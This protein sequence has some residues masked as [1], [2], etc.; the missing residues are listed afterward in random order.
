MAKRKRRPR[1]M[2]KRPPAAAAARVAPG[3]SVP[4]ARTDFIWWAAVVTAAA[5][6]AVSA[7]VYDPGTYAPFYVRE[8]MPLLAS[9]LV[10]AALAFLQGRRSAQALRLD[11]LDALAAGFAVW[12]LASVVVSPAPLVAIF[13]AYNTGHG[14]LFWCAVMLTFIALRRLLSGERSQKA[15][16]W[17][18]AAALV[19]AAAIAVAQAFGA[20]SL[21]AVWG[22]VVRQ[23]RVPGTTGSPLGL[24]AFGL[25]SI[26]MLG[27]LDLWRRYGPTWLAAMVGSAAG[28]ICVAMSV[29]RAAA[30]GFGAGVLVLAVVWWLARR[31]SDLI[32]LGCVLL[33]A[34][35]AS[36]AYGAGPGD[37]LFS[38]LQGKPGGGLNSS[39]EKR[40]MLWG[41]AAKAFAARPLTGVGSG[42]F[43]V[44]DRLYRPAA[45][46]IALPWGVGS[47]AHSL[48]LL[49]AA[50]SGA[51]GLV[52]G[53]ALLVL[54][55]VRL[56]RGAR[57]GPGATTTEIDRAEPPPVRSTAARASSE[58]ALV[59]LLA[60]AAFAALSPLYACFAVAAAVFAGAAC[61]PPRTAGGRV[62]E[63]GGARGGRAAAVARVCGLI[64]ASIALAVVLVLG[65]QWWR[66]E[67][68]LVRSAQTGSV[69]DMQRAAD[70][71]PWEPVYLLQAG[72]AVVGE[73]QRRQDEAAVAGG[74]ALLQRGVS[75]DRTAP[76]GY[77]DLARLDM[78]AGASEAAVGELRKALAWNPQHPALQGLWA[79]AALQAQRDLG[80]ERLATRLI[81]GLTQLPVDTPDGWY[82]LAQAYDA[83]GQ[84]ALAKAARERAHELNPKLDAA[85]YR[86]RLN[87]SER[88]GARA[89]PVSVTEVYPPALSTTCR[90]AVGETPAS[91][92][93]WAG[94]SVRNR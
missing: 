69:T 10:L 84:T 21:W 62:W 70:L 30:L 53:G 65:V 94:S 51:P 93:A 85:A 86:A 39:D 9:A 5:L 73:A 48:P 68:A 46:R 43:I 16:V 54:V 47:D 36:L 22:A 44:A 31:R 2:P 79:Y 89:A 13:G 41:E 49:I 63:L 60:V 42:A 12:Q 25:V 14:A 72:R 40:L 67:H 61:G 27:G 56:W 8:G 66:A 1:M 77:A 37:S 76:D 74:R 92:S 15:L 81:E 91:W 88:W 3:P 52:L 78:S 18:L 57:G 28:A 82:W 24:G 33:I 50:G 17:I 87:E 19:C 29:S 4:R 55:C 45:R 26:W 75:R 32:A 34:V 11:T 38:R 59:Y 83:R 35:L 20:T 6:I 58:A 64:G 23:D 71:W 80:D 7:V 90:R